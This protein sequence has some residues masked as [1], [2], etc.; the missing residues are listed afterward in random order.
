[1]V[2][3][4]PRE[5][6]VI[7]VGPR[8][9]W[10][11]ACRVARI[12][13]IQATD[14]AEIEPISVR[15]AE[16]SGSVI[17][18][19][20]QAVAES[21]EVTV[22]A[23]KSVPFSVVKKIMATCTGQ[24]YTGSR[25]PS[26]RK[27]R[28]PRKTGREPVEHIRRRKNGACAPGRA[29]PRAAAGLAA[30]CASS[31]TSSKPSLRSERSTQLLDRPAARSRSSASSVRRLFWGERSSPHQATEHLRRV[32]ERVGAFQAQL[33]ELDSPTPGGPRPDRGRTRSRSS[34][35]T[36]T[37]TSSRAGRAPQARVDR[38]ARDQPGAALAQVMAWAR[39]G[40]DDRRFRK[41]L[42]ASLAASLCSARCC[43]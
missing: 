36:R 6:V 43:R 39:G 33:D 29:G 42:A 31:M 3:A 12:A 37:C 4:K 11:R 1:V 9:C 40:E 22:L 38:R 28:R 34:S 35:S 41:A 16:L 30:T 7:F 20:T 25:W 32:R 21:Q 27:P 26:S 5:T 24:G 10:C 8:R 14:D 2:E 17:G 19:S 23:D 13:D 18:L 15:L